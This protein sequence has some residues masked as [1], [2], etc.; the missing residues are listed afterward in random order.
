R[1]MRYVAPLFPGDAYDTASFEALLA[2]RGLGDLDWFVERKR[3]SR[4]IAPPLDI[5][6]LRETFPQAQSETMSWLKEKTDHCLAGRFSEF[7]SAYT[8]VRDPEGG[9][10]WLEDFRSGVSWPLTHQLRTVIVKHDNISDIKTV[11]ELSRF[12]WAPNLA[13]MEALSGESK[14]RMR[15]VELVDDWQRKN[16][17]SLGPNW[18][19]SM[20]V[21]IRALNVLYASELFALS[22]PLPAPFVR[23]LYVSLY[24]HGLH[25]RNNLENQAT[26]LNTNHYLANL[27]GLLTL[28]KLFEELPEG[29]E[30]MNYALAELTQE[31]E[32]QT[33]ADG[34]CYE[35]SANYHLLVLEFYLYALAF[36]RQNEIA[37]PISYMR[38]LSIMAR[39]TEAL[40]APDGTL[41]NIGDNDSGRLFKP[42]P[43]KDR[44]PGWLMAWAVMEGIS[45][46]A[47]TSIPVNEPE[48]I[49]F[50]GYR[51]GMKNSISGPP[52][53]EDQNQRSSR[54][55]SC[56]YRESGIVILRDH[57][58]MMSVNVSDVGVGGLGG[59]KHNDQL[60]L[61]LCWG[62]DE[63]LIDPGT[64]CYTK[65]EEERN[66]LRSCAAHSTVT[67]RDAETNRFLPGYMFALRRDG[68][69]HVS[70]W[71]STPELDLL[72]AEHNCYQRLT[73]SPVV[74]RTIYFDKQQK[75]WLVRD[76]VI[77]GRGST[78]QMPEWNSALIVGDVAVTVTGQSA[79]LQSRTN[80]EKILTISS[81]T[82]GAGMLREDFDSAP[83]YGVPRNG[84]KLILTPPNES[85]EL[86]WH[87]S[88]ATEKGRR[89]LNKK[90]LAEKLKLLE[91]TADMITFADGISINKLS[92]AETGM[93]PFK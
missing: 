92:A 18:N 71:L 51:L 87:I 67:I 93:E 9:I 3:N 89:T 63:F 74:I 85:S 38:R 81:L 52:T 55:Q 1:L 78:S 88:C 39:F 48:T 2:A 79:V 8:D 33:T 26:G 37:L 40:R 11:W 25:I 10:H 68:V 17:Y 19:C 21:A 84:T 46:N 72:R 54:L 6:T 7:G 70:T 57:D 65:C 45:G 41:P 56:F 44:D 90:S 58:L 16:P 60:A 64:F 32:L 43:R 42:A 27:I 91:W 14:Y 5:P 36:C 77:P 28:G 69:P 29:K 24:Q 47:Q 80:P 12:Q 13:Q 66:R 31:I 35:S 34:F 53:P 59:H 50:Y 20:E 62:K 61:T 82:T 76:E 22:G 49:W 30:W 75:F 86:I 15:F 4:L 23:T 73:G 83:S